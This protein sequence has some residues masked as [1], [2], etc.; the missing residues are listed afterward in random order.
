MRILSRPMTLI[1]TLAVVA[2]LAAACS[3]DTATAEQTATTAAPATTEAPTTAAP[4]TEAPT[5]AAAETTT[6]A[7]EPGLDVEALTADV[8]TALASWRELNGAPGTSLAL[9]LADDTVIEVADGL[10]DMQADEPVTTDSYFRIGSISKSMTSAVVLQ[11]VDEGLIDLDAPVRTYIDGWLGDYEY[12]DEITIRQL[13]NHTNGLVEY[14]LDPSFFIFAGQRLDDDLEPEEIID[15]LSE[16]KP[17]FAPGEEYSYETGGFLTLG[18]VIEVV[19][20]NEAVDEINQRLFDA[21]GADDIYLPPDEFP[22]NP[23]VNGYGRGLMYLASFGLIGRT[24]ETGLMINGEPVADVYELPQDVL[25]SAGWTGGGIEAQLESV[26]EVMEVMFDGTVLNDAQIA[27][28]TAPTLDSN[29]GLGIDTREQD[30][31]LVYSHG[32]GV[33]G[34]RSQAGYFP[35]A[36]ISYAFSASLIPL[37]VGGGVGEMQAALI[38]VLREYELIA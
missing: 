9:V 14:A 29:Y 27:E 11:L 5:T 1:P 2:I 35:S 8:Q 3:S 21:A 31:V 37:P 22:P 12:A 20:G 15:W 13:M 4:T 32:G 23:V 7:P 26:A 34:F 30:G 33:P 38:D 17:L 18:R 10:V 19:T 6:E 36:D 24:D 25:Q 16:Q 28:M